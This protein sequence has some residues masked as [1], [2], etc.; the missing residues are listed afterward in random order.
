MT[1]QAA[2]LFLRI[3]LFFAAMATAASYW[4]YIRYW[5]STYEGKLPVKFIGWYHSSE[6][7]G[8]S[9]IKKR[10][11]MKASNIF[12]IVMWVSLALAVLFILIP[13]MMEKNGIRL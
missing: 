8:T 11:Y 9:S 7:Y 4:F 1:M 3:L 10:Q 13:L 6:M 12:I 2:V 5:R